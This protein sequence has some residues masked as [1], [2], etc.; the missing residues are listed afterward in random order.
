LKSTEPVD[1]LDAFLLNAI[2]GAASAFV[3]DVHATLAAPGQVISHYRIVDVVGEGGS[4]TVCR[5]FDAK[6]QRTVAL[7]FL[8]P[9]FEGASARLA[10]EAR[11]A[12]ALQHPA[13]CTVY[14]FDEQDGRRFLVM[15]LLEGETLKARLGRGPLP[16]ADALRAARAIASGLEAAHARG[17]VHC[18]IKPANVFLTRDGATKILD[19]G[20][21]QRQRDA[22]TAVKAANRSPLTSGTDGYMSP[23]QQRGEEVDAR[24][25]VY[26]LGVLLRQAVGRPSPA[27]H[28]LVE[29]M[30][31]PDRS[32]RLASMTDVVAAL[33]AVPRARARAW[34]P[35]LGAAALVALVAIPVAW[36]FWPRTPPMAERDFILVA[37]VD[38][39]TNNAVFDDVLTDTVGVQIG[40]SPFLTVFAGSRLADELKQ[41][42][43]PADA[44]ITPA[45][46]RDICERAGIKAFISGSIAPVGT[47]FVVR[48]EAVNARTGDFLSRQQAEAASPNDVVRIVGREADALRADLGESYQ[49]LQR[50]NVPAGSATTASLD[51]LRA[52]RQGQLLMAQGTAASAKAVPFFERATELDPDFALAYARLAAAYENMREPKRSA[53]A[54]RQAFERRERVTERERYQISAHY[55]GIVSGELSKAIEAL[56]MW[57]Q[58]FPADAPPH[59]ALSGYLKEAGQ[60]ERA[61]EQG[62]LAVRLT[63]TSALF[64]SNLAGAYMRLSNFRRATQ[65]STDA[66]AA[67]VDNSTTH[68]FLQTLAFISGD[69][70]AMAR[71]ARWR[72]SGTAAYATTEYEGSL[73]AAEG[74]FHDARELY[75]RAIALTEREGLAE[76]AAEY[77]ARLA[78]IELA[79]G[80]PADARAL[81]AQVLTQDVG[82]PIVADAAIVLA[83]V[84]DAAGLKAIERLAA[85]YPRDEHVRDL[86][87][88]LVAAAAA[89]HAGRP[90]DTVAPLRLLDTIDRGDHGLMRGA[91]SLGIASL[92]AHDARGARA[93]FE[94][95]LANRGIVALTPMY[96]LAQLG[97]ARALALDGATAEARAAYEQFFATWTRAD[98]DAAPLQQARAEYA[99]LKPAS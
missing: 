26:A 49:S 61:A 69:R 56:D 93:A 7:K 27:L 54:A 73:A 67:H 10:Q 64:H 59:N 66:V 58:A 60:L 34:R 41:M 57:T 76:R 99:R 83:S 98:A 84:G 46:A 25:D 80:R 3:A 18:D 21:A 45:M 95:V 37:A 36:R 2:G 87:R 70:D 48:L 35:A 38:N 52:F 77:R 65:V 17:L 11:A 75:P 71:E 14:D 50:F 44:R 33:D 30:T 28:R 43:Q 88:P 79:A 24:T 9:T 97:R 22:P 94:R 5:A 72:S 40:Q 15:E 32:D 6:L 96:A 92:A 1:D 91:Y 89:I 12:S 55:Y 81:A 19:F 13:I 74:R 90:A 85:E 53:D 78:A 20:I 16:E 31:A 42:R 8:A 39:H 68:R 23:E 4:G 82:R 86:W 29:R 51:A 63:P 62:E 47:G